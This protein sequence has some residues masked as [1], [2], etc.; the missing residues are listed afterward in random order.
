MTDLIP[1]VE[2]DAAGIWYAGY[3][4]RITNETV[5]L[6]WHDNEAD[7]WA[8]A[9]QAAIRDQEPIALEPDDVVPL[10]VLEQGTPIA[11]SAI[12]AMTARRWRCPHCAGTMTYRPMAV[13]ERCTITGSA[14]DAMTA[15]RWR[16]PHCDA[17]MTYR[18][19]AICERCTVAIEW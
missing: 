15:R 3:R 2:R 1:I 9:R 11:G 16:C 6:T 12:D 7:A 19:V 13:C 4:D 18:A 5:W 10:M 14:I 8:E 17:N